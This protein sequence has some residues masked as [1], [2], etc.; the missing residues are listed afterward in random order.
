[1]LVDECRATVHGPTDAGLWP[2]VQTAPAA[3]AN[4]QGWAQIGARGLSAL[5]A[6]AGRGVALVDR[7]PGLRALHGAAG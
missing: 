3:V 7:L 6:R 1:M 4:A 5:G 2:G